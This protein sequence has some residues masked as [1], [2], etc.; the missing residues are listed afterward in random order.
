MHERLARFLRVLGDRHA[1]V[2]RREKGHEH[3]TPALAPSDTV[4]GRRRRS[5]IAALGSSSPKPESGPIHPALGCRGQQLFTFCRQGHGLLG[6]MGSMSRS[7]ADRA[8][9][10]PHK[11]LARR[12]DFGMASPSGFDPAG[13]QGAATVA[14]AACAY[15]ATMAS[16]Y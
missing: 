10:P 16:A 3:R 8:R 5:G 12:F 9:S 1:P 11:R 6:S 13:H 14:L 2:F 15:D 4:R 7:P